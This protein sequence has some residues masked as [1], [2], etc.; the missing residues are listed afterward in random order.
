MGPRVTRLIGLA[1]AVAVLTI[2]TPAA[3][4]CTDG[5][6]NAHGGPPDTCNDGCAGWQQCNSATGNCDRKSEC[7]FF[8][9]A[10]DMNGER[11]HGGDNVCD[12]WHTNNHNYCGVISARASG[13]CCEDAGVGRV[14]YSWGPGYLIC[15]GQLIR[16]GAYT[17]SGPSP[18]SLAPSTA[19]PSTAAPTTAVPTAAPTLNPTAIPTADPS[20]APIT[21]S[22]TTVAPST[23]SPTTATPTISEPTRVPMSALPSTYPTASPAVAP[24]TP[25]PTTATPTTAVPTAPP[26]TSEPTRSPTATPASSEPTRIPTSEPTTSP[27]GSPAA[28][29]AGSSGS[30]AD[31]SSDSEGVVAAVVVSLFLVAG[32]V[33][34]AVVYVKMALADPR[35]PG[36]SNPVYDSAVNID[37]NAATAQHVN[38]QVEVEREVNPTYAPGPVGATT[39]GYMEVPVGSSSYVDNT[40]AG[41]TPAGNPAADDATYMDPA[42]VPTEQFGGFGGDFEEDV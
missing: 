23:P 35:A 20:T 29:A 37:I 34:A 16:S 18:T 17:A 6:N 40:P 1:S 36:F 28:A 30:A 41:N 13:C 3:F 7:M 10:N 8:A 27:S 38:G 11:N 15:N 39:A 5:Y 33:L 32:A 19:A 14:T 26:S 22:P 31:D 42:P 9:S 2:D 12:R 4:G 21:S 24:T 25:L